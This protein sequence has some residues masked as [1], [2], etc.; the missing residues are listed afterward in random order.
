MFDEFKSAM[1]EKYQERVPKYGQFE[2]YSVAEISQQLMKEIEEWKETKD[3]KKMVDIANCCAMIW[4]IIY[5]DEAREKNIQYLQT[6]LAGGE[7]VIL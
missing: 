7:N 1:D 5:N 6:R 4:M 2:R 3:F